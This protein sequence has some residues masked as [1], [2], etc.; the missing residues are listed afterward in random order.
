MKS[1]ITKTRLGVAAALLLIF[2]SSFAGSCESQADTASHNLKTEAEQFKLVRKFTVINGITDKVIFDITGRCS[3]ESSSRQLLLTCLEVDK[4]G[5]KND[6]LSQ[7]VI[8]LS[9]NTIWTMTQLEPVHVSTFRTKVIFK[10]ENILPD[11]DLVRSDPNSAPL[12]AMTP[13]PTP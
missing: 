2:M 10:P 8:G 6:Q 12:P 11:V 4:P 7:P 1:K 13:T 5:D 3:Y 9:D